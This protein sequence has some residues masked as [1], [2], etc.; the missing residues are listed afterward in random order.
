MSNNI[1]KNIYQYRE[2][3]KTNIRKDIRGR[4]KGSFLGVLWSFINPLLQSLVYAIVFPYLL[5]STGN[6]YIVYLVVGIIPWTFFLTTV[7]A[8]TTSIKANAGIIKKVYFPREILPLSQALSGLINFFISCIII[9]LFCLGFRIGITYHI[10][11]V[12]VIAIIQMFFVLGLSFILSAF[13]AYIQ[14]TEYIVGFILTMAFY[15]SPIVYKLEQFQAIGG[16]KAAIIL[17]LIKLNPM[18]II[19]TGY[20]NA[21]MYHMWPNW[22]ELLYVFL[23]GII[24][25]VIGYFIFK[26]LEKGFAEQF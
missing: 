1:F 25:V 21:F 4:Y 24:L 26:K 19:I 14:D 5:G 3:L 11:A 12:P 10:L 8:G 13:N 20:R 16:G 17:K 9:I 18:T 15:A 22:N 7:S 6:N 2:L 23:M